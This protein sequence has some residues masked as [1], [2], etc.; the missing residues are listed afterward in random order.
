MKPLKLKIKILYRVDQQVPV[1]KSRARLHLCRAIP[2]DDLQS[3]T[4][5]TIQQL[6]QFHLELSSVPVIFHI[7]MTVLMLS[8]YC[9]HVKTFTSG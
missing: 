5:W 6:Y 8:T 9:Q 2:G 7:A 3:H 4:P 1:E